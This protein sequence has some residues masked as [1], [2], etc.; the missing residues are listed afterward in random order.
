M[1]QNKIIFFIV[2][3]DWFFLSHRLQ[4]ALSMKE[5]GYDVYILAK[6]TGKRDEIEEN[7]LRFININFE[8]SGKEPLKE[9][10]II[11]QLIE[12]YRKY[13]PD[14]IHNVTI[15]PAIYSSIAFKFYKKKNVKFVNAISGLGYNFIDNRNG[16]LQKVLKKLMRF[17]YKGNVNFIFQNPDDKQL[18]QEMHFL[19]DNNFHIIKGAGVDSEIFQYHEPT[20]KD[21]I[22]IVFV[23]RMLRDKGVQEFVDAAKILQLKWCDKANFKLVGDVDEENLSGIKKE[24]LNAMTVSGYIYW[25]GY[26]K[27]VQSV[28]ISSDIAC[29]PSYREGLPKSLIEAM[30]IGRPIVTTDVPGCRECVE[31]GING[32]LVPAQ[33]AQMLAEALDILM[34]NEELRLKMGR[35]SREK[36]LKEMSLQQVITETQEFYEQI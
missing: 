29:L 24:E 19:K 15:K 3:V 18:Y 16:L 32:F 4:L 1:D 36:M 17:A 34:S 28:L 10:L 22:E 30:A 21:K 33:N 12:L 35:A 9:I 5:R 2:N 13:K 23:A 27:D 11:K 7:G 8:R 26:K 25:E 31:E 20:L 6:D 14:I